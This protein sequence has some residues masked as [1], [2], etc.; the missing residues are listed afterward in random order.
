MPSM[1][2]SIQPIETE[3]RAHFF[4]HKTKEHDALAEIP[5]V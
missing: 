4:A 1:T 2:S 3:T 5:L